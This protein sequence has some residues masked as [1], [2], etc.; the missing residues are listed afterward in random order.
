MPNRVVKLEQ[1]KNA[2]EGSFNDV[3]VALLRQWRN[4]HP[5]EVVAD[6]QRGVKLMEQID[7]I[8]AVLAISD[9]NG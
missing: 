3:L 5:A 1:D 7:A 8:E 6:L 9:N 2:L 4:M